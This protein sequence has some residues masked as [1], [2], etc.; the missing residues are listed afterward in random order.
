MATTNWT[1]VKRAWA[2]G[3]AIQC[4]RSEHGTWLDYGSENRLDRSENM[5]WRVKP[6]M[7]R[8]RIVR[9]ADGSSIYAEVEGEESG[10]VDDWVSE[11]IDIPQD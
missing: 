7:V 11:W 9:P 4:K 6:P 3:R 8:A 2:E 10:S 1:E 5:D